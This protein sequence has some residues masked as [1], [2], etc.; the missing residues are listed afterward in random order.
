MLWIAVVVVMGIARQGPGVLLDRLPLLCGREARVVQHG[1]CG[2][3]AHKT[4]PGGHRR[5]GAA[6]RTMLEPGC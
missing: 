2:C 1:L 3:C 4:R 5:L 6:R